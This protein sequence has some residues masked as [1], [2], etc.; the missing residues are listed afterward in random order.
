[1]QQ[2][3]IIKAAAHTRFEESS[4]KLKAGDGEY[5]ESRDAALD[6]KSRSD[7]TPSENAN[8]EIS[9]DGATT[10]SKAKR[11]KGKTR[12]KSQSDGQVAVFNTNAPDD[13]ERQVRKKRK[14]EHKKQ[15]VPEN[16]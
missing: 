5:L 13:E 10:I 7:T 14:K 2:Q 8:G 15:K 11:P 4:Q 16:H 1:M 9:L 12:K 3:V 6:K